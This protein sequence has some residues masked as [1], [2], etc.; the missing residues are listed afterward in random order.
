MQQVTQLNNN[1][2]GEQTTGQPLAMPDK[3]IT[4]PANSRV[5]IYF[6]ALML[7][8]TLNLT[9]L[10]PVFF[11]CVTFLVLCVIF[12]AELEN[13]YRLESSLRFAAAKTIELVLVEAE[14]K[15]APM[16]AMSAGQQ[17]ATQASTQTTQNA[18]KAPSTPIAPG[19]HIESDKTHSPGVKKTL[20]AAAVALSKY[21]QRLVR[22]GFYAEF[23]EVPI[24]LNYFAEPRP[25]MR[26][27]FFDRPSFHIQFG[28]VRGVDRNYEPT[29]GEFDID[30]F[31][32]ESDDVFEILKQLFVEAATGCDYSDWEPGENKN[33]EPNKDVPEAPGEFTLENDTPDTAEMNKLTDKQNE[34]LTAEATQMADELE[35]ELDAIEDNLGPEWDE[36]GDEDCYDYDEYNEYEDEDEDDDDDFDDDDLNNLTPS[37]V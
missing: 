19:V 5:V 33:C 4:S 24:L 1:T 35:S 12:L 31:L 7:L 22:A 32:S 8:A 11:A 34:K 9:G 15:G 18:P 25:D 26:G 14:K 21:K 6:S 29:F 37:R 28:P 20:S 16:V 27:F 10:E 23:G 2:P 30:L 3:L 17:A 13:A 36:E